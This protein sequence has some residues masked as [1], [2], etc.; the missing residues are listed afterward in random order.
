[1]DEQLKQKIQNLINSSK[2]FLFMKGTPEEPRCGFSMQVANILK[3]SGI[4]F[5]SFD[6]LTDESIRQGIK[7]FA[8]WPTIP[9]V[10]IH[11]KFIGGCDIVTEMARKGELKGI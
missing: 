3:Q 8:D 6:V 4:P 7:E 10:Y 1:M 2:V 9:Q 5:K 11:G